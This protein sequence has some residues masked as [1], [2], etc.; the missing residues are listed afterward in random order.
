MFS[1]RHRVMFLE[2][3][4]Y[5]QLVYA[6]KFECEVEYRLT[7]GD[8]HKGWGALCFGAGTQLEATNLMASGWDGNG[9]QS[10]CPQNE[11][12]REKQMGQT[13]AGRQTQHLI[14]AHF[15][16]RFCQGFGDQR[17]FE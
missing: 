10:C 9:G 4:I 7:S 5:F 17:C 12:K 8:F 16:V 3:N 11:G 13:P 15:S 2:K 14:L 1:S 6:L